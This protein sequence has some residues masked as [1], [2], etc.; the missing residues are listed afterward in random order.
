[1]ERARALLRAPDGSETEI[2]PG[3]LIGRLST[4]VICIDDPR[5]SEAHA[6]VS[7]RG[8]RLV[9]LALRGALRAG[10]ARV[11]RVELIPGAEVGLVEGIGLTVLEVWLPATVLGVSVGGGEAAPLSASIYS[12]RDG[13][14]VPGYDAGAPVVI[15]SSADGW[16]VRSGGQT[17]ALVPGGRWP[18]PGGGALE[19]VALPVVAASADATVAS[20]A[21][22]PRLTLVARQETVHIH[23]EDQVSAVITGRPARILCELVDFDAPVP[24]EVVAGQIWPE[25]RDDRYLL[26]Q[27]WD[28]QSRLLRL[29]LREAG[30]REDL[31]RP[32]GRGNI[33]LY[34]FPGDEVV[35]QR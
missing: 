31:A 17:A 8:G 19:A 26:R 18:L 2:G 23:R 12:V 14:P 6:M 24:W 11:S 21:D 9:M 5:I 34:L 13:A 29:R 10:E 22:H 20:S 32:D 25:R 1:M 27:N 16:R 7:L 15:W 3:G 30:L 28:R 33:E 4:A 35:D